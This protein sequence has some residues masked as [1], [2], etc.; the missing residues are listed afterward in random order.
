MINFHARPK[1]FSYATR[2]NYDFLA[3]N[4]ESGRELILSVA[5]E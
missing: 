5:R 4:S 2:A 1:F 3:S